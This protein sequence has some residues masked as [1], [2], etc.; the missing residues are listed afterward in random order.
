M[1][2]PT[3]FIMKL[4][5]SANIQVPTGGTIFTDAFK[6]GDVDYFA[7]SY[8]VSCTGV[9][10]VRIQMEQSIYQPTT[11]NVPDVNFGVPKSVG[12]IET[13]LTSKTIQH[14]QLNPV[15]LSYVRFKITEQTGLVTDTVVNLWLSLQKKFTQ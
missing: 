14:M 13:A 1:N 6:F 15:T 4:A 7:L 5:G 8:K 10:N 2:E 9:P 3:V 12:D 11:D